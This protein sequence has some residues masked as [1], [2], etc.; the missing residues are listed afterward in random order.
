MT[1][2]HVLRT[3]RAVGGSRLW[4]PVPGTALGQGLPPAADCGVLCQRPWLKPPGL[5]HAPR[6]RGALSAGEARSRLKW[7]DGKTIKN[8]VDL[9][10]GA[11]T[12][13]QALLEVV[14]PVSAVPSPSWPVPWEGL[15]LGR[16][17]PG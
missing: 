6:P 10:V 11:R 2:C 16:A 14:S 7:A 12:A 4:C 9:Q 15:V 8:E 17:C 1:S 13:G 5:G 3:G